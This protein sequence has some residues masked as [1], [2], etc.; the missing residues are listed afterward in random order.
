MGYFE[1]S[2]DTSMELGSVLANIILT[3]DGYVEILPTDVAVKVTGAKI[4]KIELASL[5]KKI[6]TEAEDGIYLIGYDLEPGTYKV[7]VTDTTTKMGYVERSKSLAMNLDDIIANEIIQGP[8][9][10][11]IKEGDFA[12]RLQGV[13]ITKQ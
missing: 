6:K 5:E 3:G 10:V 13:K 12:I 11:D 4:H 9:Y 7:E 2:K 8:G 1:R